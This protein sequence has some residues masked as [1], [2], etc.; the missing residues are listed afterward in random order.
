MLRKKVV[1]YQHLHRARIARR[2][3]LAL[4]ITALAGCVYDSSNRCGP[5]QVLQS[6]TSTTVDVCVC[7][8]HSV[9]TPTGCTPCGANE[10]GSATGCQCA[11]GYGRASSLDPCAPC[12]A[13]EVGSATG[14]QCAPG[15]GRASPSDPCTQGFDA[16]IPLDASVQTGQCASDGDCTSGSACDLRVTPSVC[17]QPPAGQGKTCASSADCAGTEAT[18]CDSFV[19]KTCVVQGCSVAANDCFP[20]YTCCDLS[21]FG[22]PT[23]C[24]VGGVCP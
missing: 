10:V 4:S 15:Y 20:G 5:H 21:K 11:P 6:A 24:V 16:G 12:G 18:F 1:G 19:T 22:L 3:I 8:E 13:N 2:A 7:D 14:C 17:R 9:A 23:V